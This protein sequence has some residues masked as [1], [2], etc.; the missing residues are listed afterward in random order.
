MSQKESG[1]DVSVRG[2]P[3]VRERVIKES[4]PRKEPKF[5]NNLFWD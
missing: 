3:P 5:L 4:Y 1:I 2:V